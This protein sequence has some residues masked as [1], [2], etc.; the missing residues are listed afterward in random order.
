[1]HVHYYSATHQS[2]IYDVVNDIQVHPLQKRTGGHKDEL[3]CIAC[4]RP[5]TRHPV[6]HVCVSVGGCD[7]S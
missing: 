2:L 5:S 7:P 1:M 6:S 4:I 3:Y